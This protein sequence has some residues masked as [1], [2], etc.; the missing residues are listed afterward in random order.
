MEQIE[1]TV[2][3]ELKG[4]TY[5]INGIVCSFVHSISHHSLPQKCFVTAIFLQAL[6]Y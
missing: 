5:R 1:A 6:K 2:S 4:Q 3:G